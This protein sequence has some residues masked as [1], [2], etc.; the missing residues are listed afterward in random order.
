MS[1][2]TMDTVDA[3]ELAELLQFLENWLDTGGAGVD[4]S[5]RAFVGADYGVSDLREDLARFTALLGLTE[6]ESSVRHTP[7]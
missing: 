5:L 2:I 1:E 6:T 4:L 3:I 7:R